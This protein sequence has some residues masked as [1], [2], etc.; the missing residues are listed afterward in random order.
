MLKCVI[1]GME[2]KASNGMQKTCSR[3]CSAN[4][5]QR[6]MENRTWNCTCI[7]CGKKFKTRT[8]RKT[9]SEECLTRNKRLIAGKERKAPVDY[10][11]PYVPK[12]DLGK[13]AVEA[14]KHGMSYGQYYAQAYAPKWSQER[15]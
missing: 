11:T 1:C 9:C 7:V 14:S 12:N 5:K 3:V 10:I 8:N 13:A 6:R 4:L 15:K 2:F